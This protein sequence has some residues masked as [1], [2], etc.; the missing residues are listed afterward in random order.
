MTAEMA[1]T[2]AAMLVGFASTA[3]N[4]RAWSRRPYRLR[5]GLYLWAAFISFGFAM[6]YLLGLIG[7]ISLAILVEYL[8]LRWFA[9]LALLGLLLHGLIDT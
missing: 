5:R 4:L 2:I 9:L 3:V 6:A 8:V 7:V 1:V